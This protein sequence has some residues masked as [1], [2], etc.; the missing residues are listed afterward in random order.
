MT[1]MS[2]DYNGA[3]RCIL[4]HNDSQNSINTDA[5]KDNHGLGDSFSPTDLLASSLAAC[6]VTILGIKN[7][8]LNLG[9]LNMNA[10]IEKSMSSNPRKVNQIHVNLT[11]ELSSRN[12]NVEKQIQEIASTCPV[13][14]SI[15]PDTTQV[16]NITYC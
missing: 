10:E 8:N 6:M 13:A 15:H 3:L 7:E 14:L 11:V 16:I 1:K 2:L 4:T 5:P 9:I 12:E